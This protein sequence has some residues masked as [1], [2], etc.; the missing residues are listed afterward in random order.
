MRRIVYVCACG[1]L[2]LLLACGG[3]TTATGLR[4]DLQPQ[5]AGLRGD[6]QPQPAGLR[7]DMIRQPAPAPLIPLP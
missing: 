3:G 2:G 6:L 7:G 4:G 5:P 1:L